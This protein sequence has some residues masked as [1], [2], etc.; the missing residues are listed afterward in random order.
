MPSKNEEIDYY[1]FINKDK[2][3]S[4]VS[5][6]VFPTEKVL[7]PQSHPCDWRKNRALLVLVGGL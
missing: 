7:T 6:F 3:F 2:A 5:R 4:V 1:Y